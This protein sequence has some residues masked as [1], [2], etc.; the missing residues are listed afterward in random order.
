MYVSVFARALHW[1]QFWTTWIQSTTSHHIS[2]GFILLL[3]SHW[4]SGQSIAL[5]VEN[6]QWSKGTLSSNHVQL[7]CI[8]YSRLLG[9]DCNVG[10]AVHIFLKDCSSFIFRAEDLSKCLELLTQWYTLILEDLNLSSTAG[11]NSKSHCTW[12][13][14]KGAN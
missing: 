12:W 8:E 11:R 3:S 4:Y 2:V 13:K 10:W 5:D 9:C 1:S 14:T 6:S 7:M